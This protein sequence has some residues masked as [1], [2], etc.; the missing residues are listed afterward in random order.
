MP[1]KD[2]R[3]VEQR[4][5]LNENPAGRQNSVPQS[6]CVSRGI[7][8][9]GVG[10]YFPVSSKCLTDFAKAQSSFKGKL[11]SGQTINRLANQSAARIK[12]SVPVPSGI[13]SEWEILIRLGC[14]FRGSIIWST[15]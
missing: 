13:P 5:A 1:A 14:S 9:Q 11:P 3:R 12:I 2:M 8:A 7:A 15:L 10:L 4:R 6:V